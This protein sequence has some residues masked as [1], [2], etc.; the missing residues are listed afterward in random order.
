MSVFYM[1]TCNSITN[2]KPATQR[3]TIGAFGI[4]KRTVKTSQV[5]CIGSSSLE[6]YVLLNNTENGMWVC[7]GNVQNVNLGNA[8]YESWP[9]CC[10]SWLRSFVFFFSPF[11]LFWGSMLTDED[12]YFQILCNS[13]FI[14]HLTI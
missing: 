6:C 10:L 2:N 11:R 12:S 13:L 9:G 7:S 14:T 8:Y 1:L 4:I 5:T 3:N